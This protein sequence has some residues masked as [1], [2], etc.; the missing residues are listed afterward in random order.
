[1]SEACD[2]CGLAWACNSQP[3][4]ESDV[5]PVISDWLIA[6]LQYFVPLVLFIVGII[7]SLLISS[8]EII[9]FISG[10]AGIGLG[11]LISRMI[12]SKLVCR[13]TTETP[14]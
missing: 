11:G 10:L 9:A 7:M 13:N 6:V 8:N 2:Q 12:F 3:E 4:I 14:K 5:D 1:M